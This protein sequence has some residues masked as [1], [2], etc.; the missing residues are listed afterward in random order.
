MVATETGLPTNKSRV[1]QNVN[2]YRRRRRHHYYYYY[3]CRC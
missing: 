3:Y 2:Y 1:V